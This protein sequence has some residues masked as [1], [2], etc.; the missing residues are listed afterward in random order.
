MLTLNKLNQQAAL[1]TSP[2][3]H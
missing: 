1:P 2:A 3:A